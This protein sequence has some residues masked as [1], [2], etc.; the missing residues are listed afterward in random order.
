MDSVMTD[1]F[2]EMNPVVE[3]Q[4]HFT[5]EWVNAALRQG[6]LQ[7][8]VTAV[9]SEQIGIGQIGACFRLHLRHDGGAPDTLIAKTAAGTAEQRARVGNG[10]RTE[11]NFYTKLAKMARLRIPQCFYAAISDDLLSFT[12]LLED[13]YPAVPG[14]QNE[15][16]DMAQAHA[17]LRNLAGL[18]APFWNNPVLAEEASWLGN[19]HEANINMICQIQAHAVARFTE[20]YQDRL[21]QEEIDLLH[22]AAALTGPWLRSADGPRS[23]LHG[24]YRVDNLMFPPEHDGTVMAVDWQT[25]DVGLPTRDLAY[26]I[27]TAL[28]SELRRVHEQDLVSSYHEQLV[29]YGVQ[30][31]SLETCRI[32]YQRGMLQAPVI[33]ILGWLVA[34]GERSEKSE[35]MFVSLAHRMC[36]ALKEHDVV[37]ML[38]QQLNV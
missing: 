17:A 38:K 6:G 20:H 28:P 25:M 22:S 19:Y 31:Y 13:A 33:V 35:Q 30:D 12:L 8:N 32:D 3:D 10:Y 36:S 15:G 18:H 23:L 14:N 4:R 27:S 21:S 34:T 9:E 1:I 29:A 24:D 16:C 37:N 7:V 26:F 11:V 2:G 5:P